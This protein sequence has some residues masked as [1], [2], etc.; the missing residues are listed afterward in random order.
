[1]ILFTTNATPTEGK[2]NRRKT[3]TAMEQTANATPTAMKHKQQWN[4]PHLI[5]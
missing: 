3:Q 1:M 4:S 5:P 2:H